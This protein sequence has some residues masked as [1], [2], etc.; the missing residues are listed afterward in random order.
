MDWA[1]SRQV[2]SAST[3]IESIEQLLELLEEASRVGASAP[4]RGAL[5]SSEDIVWSLLKN[6]VCSYTPFLIKRCI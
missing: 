5:H 2:K 3:T 6:K 1:I 4:K